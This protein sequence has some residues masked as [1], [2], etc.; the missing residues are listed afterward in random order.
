MNAQPKR[1]RL[2][3]AKGW[4]MPPNTVKV[5]RPGPW[6]NPF[7]VGRDGTAVECVEMHRMLLAGN[8]AL[9]ATASIDEQRRALDYARAHVH[10]LVDK[11]VACWCQLDK[12][13]HGDNL[14]ELA[15]AWDKKRRGKR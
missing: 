10:T 12:P 9:T 11:N 5:S 14:L 8:W 15:A 4:R 3:R 13:C 1:I 7:K 2:S 6:G